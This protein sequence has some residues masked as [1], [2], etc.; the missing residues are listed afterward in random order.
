MEDYLGAGQCLVKPGEVRAGHRVDQY[1]PRAV[2]PQLHEEGTMPV[3]EPRGAL[4]VDG[5]RP[6]ARGQRGHGMVQGGDR[7]HQR[8]WPVPWLEQRDRAAPRPVRA[9]TVVGLT[10]A[11]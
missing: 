9:V 1:G 5:D 6:V 7:G 11:L 10:A 2:A 8:R 4:G 3:T